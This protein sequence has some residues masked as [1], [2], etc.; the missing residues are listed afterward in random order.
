MLSLYM[1]PRKPPCHSKVSC[2]GEVKRGRE[3]FFLELVVSEPDIF[4]TLARILVL[5]FLMKKS[6]HF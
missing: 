6:A 5:E 1:L 4:C 2:I 3:I